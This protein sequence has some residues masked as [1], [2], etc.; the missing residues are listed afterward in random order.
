MKEVTIEQPENDLALK[1]QAIKNRRNRLLVAVTICIALCLILAGVVI[2]YWNSRG[3]TAFEGKEYADETILSIC[4]DGAL[5]SVKGRGIANDGRCTQWVFEYL[6][7]SNNKTYEISVYDNGT[8]V[9]T[10][11]DI[12]DGRLSVEITDWTLDSTD[13]FDLAKKDIIFSR[14]RSENVETIGEIY[15]RY[16]DIEISG[17]YINQTTWFFSLWSGALFDDPK[18]A[19]IYVDASNGEIV[20][21]NAN[22]NYHLDSSKK[23]ST[24]NELKPVAD[25][26]IASIDPDAVFIGASA[27]FHNDM[28]GNPSFPVWVFDYISPLTKK[29]IEVRVN[30]EMHTDWLAGHTDYDNI[31]NRTDIEVDYWTLDSNEAYSVA[32]TNSTFSSFAD[33]YGKNSGFVMIERLYYQVPYHAGIEYGGEIVWCVELHADVMSS[34]TKL[35]RLILDAETGEIYWVT[36]YEID[37]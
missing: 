7:P 37:P 20:Y 24:A 1:T 17:Y 30:S 11:R 16:L 10:S 6:S 36:H 15:L 21:V 8:V 13:A 34:S 26:V 22:L 14:F 33:E 18:S 3:M 29:S 35:V 23:E 31:V 2:V 5:V 27:S 32:Y 28:D 9:S 25:E 19:E 12:A 4:R